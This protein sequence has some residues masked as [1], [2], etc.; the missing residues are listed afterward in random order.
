MQLKVN[1]KFWELIKCG[2]KIWWFEAMSKKLV[3]GDYQIVNDDTKACDNVNIK[4][5][6][7]NVIVNQDNDDMGGYVEPYF[8]DNNGYEEVIDP[9]SIIWLESHFMFSE[10]PYN[11][12]KIIIKK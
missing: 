11:V 2:E 9:D 4:L 12:Y 3:D 10:T 7:T 8:R 5:Y 1:N 6:T